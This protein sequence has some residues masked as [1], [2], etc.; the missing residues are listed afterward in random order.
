MNSILSELNAQLEKYN[1]CGKKIVFNQI[2]FP[3]H[4]KRKGSYKCGESAEVLE[5]LDGF[6][7]CIL[8]CPSCQAGKNATEKAIEIVK[9]GI[10][11]IKDK[12]DLKIS[13]AE[14]HATTQSP[15]E[16]FDNLREDVADVLKET[17]GK[18]EG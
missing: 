18:V 11:E 2:E 1:G 16:Y 17:L 15:S 12:I 9:A 8:I 10:K 13:W 3:S 14:C 7:K 4:R 6:K 5:D